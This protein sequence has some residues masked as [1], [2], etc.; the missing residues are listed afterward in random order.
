[1]KEHRCQALLPSSHVLKVFHVLGT[2]KS[3]RIEIRW[4]G[5]RLE[6]ATLS[7][8]P[9]SYSNIRYLSLQPL[10]RSD[11]Q[12]RDYVGPRARGMISSILLLQRLSFYYNGLIPLPSSQ[13][14]DF[15][16]GNVN[17]P[18]ICRYATLLLTCSIR[19]KL[20][21]LKLPSHRGRVIVYLLGS[22]TRMSST[23]LLPP[24]PSLPNY[25][26][27]ILVF[28]KSSS[29]THLQVVTVSDSSLEQP[30]SNTCKAG[31][32]R[33]HLNAKRLYR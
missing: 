5:S 28:N 3:Y 25:S 6:S 23:T 8:W 20:V 2:P 33:S 26:Y 29:I 18:F 31:Q 9:S 16:S 14:F 22:L 15:R 13:D 12:G 32:P 7:V 11:T 10:D 30:S 24:H 27:P 4:V 19:L 1:M 17:E 21:I